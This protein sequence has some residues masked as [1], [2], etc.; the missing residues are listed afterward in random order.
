M[1]LTSRNTFL[2][3]ADDTE[4]F[5]IA[6]KY[7]CLLAKKSDRYVAVL[8]VVEAPEIQHWGTLEEQMKKELRRKGEEFLWGIARDIYEYSGLRPCLYMEEGD[9]ISAVAELIKNDENI[10]FL[11]L[12]G[13]KGS[14]GPLVSY[15]MGKGME[16][17]NVPMMIVPGHFEEESLHTLL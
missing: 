13:G 15:F 8:N 6:W 1:F 4:E 5:K 9:R 3:I 10:R 12:G 2:V 14:P 11:V 16:H 7:A 17:L